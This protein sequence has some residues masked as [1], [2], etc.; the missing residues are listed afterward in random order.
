MLRDASPKAQANGFSGEHNLRTKLTR[1]DPFMSSNM[2]THISKFISLGAKTGGLAAL[3]LAATLDGTSV[4]AQQQTEQA[5]VA[6]P[7]GA[8]SPLPV[9]SNSNT[10]APVQPVGYVSTDSG[11]ALQQLQQQV[12]QQ[13]A[14]LQ[15]QQVQVQALVQQ[16]QQQSGGSADGGSAQA[17]AGGAGVPGYVVAS[18]RALAGAWTPGGPVFASKNGDFKFHDERRPRR[19]K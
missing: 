15:A 18:D 11:D 5:P 17:P 7:A 2:F 19:R 16:L 9:V 8:V 6:Q 13:Q 10:T 14:A 3:L 12:A 4:L 1:T